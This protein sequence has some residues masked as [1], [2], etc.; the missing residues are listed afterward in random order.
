VTLAFA[1]LVRLAILVSAAERRD[2][3]VAE[4]VRTKLAVTEDAADALLA[5]AADDGLTRQAAEGWKLTA[6]GHHLAENAAATI[7]RVDVHRRERFRP[8]T[9]Y[10]PRGW[11]AE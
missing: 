9:D 5:R 4:Y 10:L 6:A 3:D 1:T 11:A 8:Y 2:L 7:D